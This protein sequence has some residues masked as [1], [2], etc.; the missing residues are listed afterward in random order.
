MRDRI[1]A[2]GDSITEGFNDGGINGNVPYAVVSCLGFPGRFTHNALANPSADLPY[3]V[4]LGQSGSM[5]PD[6]LARA[7][8]IIEADHENITGCV[9]SVWSPN[10]L[11]PG[12]PTYA[13]LQ[14]TLDELLIVAQDFH[15]YLLTRSIIPFPT[16]LFASPYGVG[17]AQKTR[18]K[19]F[20][21]QVEA[22][23]PYGFYPGKVSTADG[24]LADPAYLSLGMLHGSPTE[25]ATH[26]TRGPEGYG[27]MHA[28]IAAN[29][30]ANRALAISTLGFSS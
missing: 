30:A 11:T 18:L 6:Y 1:L 12:D 3:F 4:N 25:D 13:F 22:L 5:V 7:K 26:P 15:D 23:F 29:Y 24:G 10:T 28:Y 9:F 2:V 21:D 20:V 27:V 8:G 14:T 16:F 17:D 19:L